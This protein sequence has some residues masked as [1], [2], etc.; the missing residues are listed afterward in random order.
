MTRLLLSAILITYFS[1]SFSQIPPGYYDGTEGLT[2]ENLRSALHNIIKDHDSQSYSSIWDHFQDTDKKANGYVWDMYSDIPGS[3]PAYTFTF[4]TDQCGNYGGEGDCYNREHSFPKSWFDNQ[5]PM[6]TDIFHI[7]PTDGYVNGKRNNYA[8]GE[9]AAASWTSTNGSKVGYCTYPGYTGVVFEPI[10]EYK[11]DFARTYFYMLTRYMDKISGWDSPMLAGNN[12]SD[13]SKYMLMEWATEDIISEKEID[14][15]NEVF[16]IQDNRNPFIDH[17]EFMEAI[18][19]PMPG[20][21][22]EAGRIA[23]MWIS[24]GIIYV[25]CKKECDGYISVYNITGQKM[26]ELNVNKTEY[27][28]IL[29]L[30][31]GAYIAILTTKSGQVAEKFIQ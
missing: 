15:N 29:E 22:E 16:Q 7:Y 12:F 3:T 8:Y 6:N 19:G 25:S 4:V 23:N 17:P 27:H 2:G 14:R 5:A 11:G 30:K 20:I 1:L 10:D 21:N 18:W 28:Q 24:E 26:L 9:I 31:S 13:W